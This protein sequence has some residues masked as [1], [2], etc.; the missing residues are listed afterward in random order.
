MTETLSFPGLGLEFE[1]NRVAFTIGSRPI[2]WYGIIVA[3]AF[4]LAALYILA[5]SKIFGLDSDRVM[6]VVIGSVLVGIGGARIYYVLFRWATYSQDPVSAFYI[7]EGGIAI[8]GGIIGGVVAALFICKWRKVKLLPMFDLAAGGLL[9]GQAVGRWGNFVNIEVFGGNTTAAWGM[10]SPSISWYIQQN[11]GD[12][13]RIGMSVD[14]SL[15][16][17]PTFFYESLWC[18]I[19][20]LFVAWYTGR[21]RFDGE[22]WLIYLGWYGLGR[23]FIEGMRTDSLLLGTIR[24]S[25]AVALICVLASVGALAVIRSK[26]K[27]ANDPE[28]LKLYVGTDEAASILSGEFYK[29]KDKKQADSVAEAEFEEES[30]SGEAYEQGEEPEPGEEPKPSEAVTPEGESEA[31]IDDNQDSQIEQAEQDIQEVQEIHKTQ[32]KQEEDVDGENN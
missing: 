14:P 25:Q 7:W 1:I 31:G 30:G 26:I 18:L 10:T 21:R 28:Y 11:M 4:L 9:I 20:F 13:N 27:R 12:L 32:Q 2:Y 19:G 8:Y 29:K 22:L 6:D 23:F 3:A 16:V 15:P 24:V 5:R 17:H